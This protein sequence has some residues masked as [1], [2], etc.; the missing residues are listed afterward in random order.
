MYCV[1]EITMLDKQNYEWI[2]KQLPDDLPQ[3][4]VEAALDNRW[5][6]ID[7]LKLMEFNDRGPSLTVYSAKDED[8]FRIYLYKEI[9]KQIAEKLE[10]LHREQN[11][12]K[13]R[14]SRDHVSED[15]KWCYVERKTYV[16]NA[17]ED[18]HL[19]SFEDY[20]RLTKKGLSSEEWEKEIIDKVSL[21]NHWFHKPH[22]DYDK[23]RMQF[24][25]ISDELEC[26]IAGGKK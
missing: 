15:K 8:D 11:A 9:C 24:I 21:L 23:E 1:E 4:I 20:L 7:G 25:E 13:W 19:A 17:I 18:T 6:Y 16:Y 5:Q 2:V 22:W 14:Y 26:E 3:D 12:L 10:L